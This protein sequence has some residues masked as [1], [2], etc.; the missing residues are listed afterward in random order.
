MWMFT[1]HPTQQTRVDLSFV[2]AVTDF[3]F[4]TVIFIKTY[5]FQPTLVL[6]GEKQ[7]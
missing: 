3:T 7:A 1:K 5:R 4:M 6:Y 2:N